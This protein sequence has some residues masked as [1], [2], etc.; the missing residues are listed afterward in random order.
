MYFADA[1]KSI[2]SAWCNL[3]LF[4]SYFRFYRQFS[5]CITCMTLPCHLLFILIYLS[6]TAC[7]SSYDLLAT[8]GFLAS[9]FSFDFHSTLMFPSSWA[10]ASH[11]RLTRLCVLVYHS[12]ITSLGSFSVK[13][14]D[15]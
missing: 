3:Y 4:T 11:V 8:A 2:C 14:S 10:E 5:D 15:E 6:C 13:Q 7:C 12:S 1:R 9:F